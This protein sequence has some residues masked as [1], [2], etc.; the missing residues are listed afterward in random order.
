MWRNNER[1]KK[2]Q[3]IPTTLRSTATTI[4]RRERMKHRRDETEHPQF[5]SSVF[6]LFQR[7]F[8]WL[9]HWFSPQLYQVIV[10]PKKEENLNSI[11]LSRQKKK[12]ISMRL[13]EC[14]LVVFFSPFFLPSF[15]R[16]WF[17]SDYGINT[18]VVEIYG[19]LAKVR[20]Y[21]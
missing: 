13:K 18:V 2:I 20:S 16:L 3:R 6:I 4:A 5:N 17:F 15:C 19:P 9:S 14:F 10:T 12:N 7:L 21:L 11:Y 8:S 1:E